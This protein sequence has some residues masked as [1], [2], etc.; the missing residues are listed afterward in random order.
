MKEGLTSLTAF[1]VASIRIISAGLVLLPIAVIYIS[2]IPLKTLILIFLSG[3]LG[4]LLPAYLF[5]MAEVNIDSSLA[6][7]LNALTPVFALII[8]N[9]FFRSYTSFIKIVGIC[10]SFGGSILLFFAQPGFQQNN[11]IMDVAFI[12]IATLSYGININLVGKFLKNIPSLQIAAIALV[13]NAV[14]ALVILY[15]T[16]YFSLNVFAKP[17]L[18][19]TAFTFVLGIAGT[20]FAS[21]IFYILIKRAGVVFS[22]MVTYAI[23]IIAVLWGVVYGEQV[24]WKQVVCL[25]IILCGVYITNKPI[26]TSA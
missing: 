24:G 20:A 22:S 10:I 13:L 25:A 17:L 18:T 3:V 15:F 8:G 2:K 23:P 7:T 1:Q 16:G 6:G 14:P 21:V 4:S 26:K 11:N 19:A 9:M 12:V 5:C